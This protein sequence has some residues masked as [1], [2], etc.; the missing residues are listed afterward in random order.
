M[1]GAAVLPEAAGPRFGEADMRLVEA[2][3]GAGGSLARDSSLASQTAISPAPRLA[4]AK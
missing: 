1:P 2:G 4:Q 3:V